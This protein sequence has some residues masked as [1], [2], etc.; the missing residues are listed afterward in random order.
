MKIR[1]AVFAKLG[2]FIFMGLSAQT[3]A[4]FGPGTTWN[5]YN[6]FYL[7]PGADGWTGATSPSALGTAWGYY[8]GNVN[9][10]GGNPDKVGNNL[11]STQ[12]YRLSNANPAGAA[13][14]VY[15]TSGWANTGG[16]GFGYYQDNVAWNG[17]NEFGVANP[18][19][20]VSLGRYD[21]PWFSGAPGLSQ[22]LSNL[23]WM[24]SAW[25]GGNGTAGGEG[26]ASVLT[27]TAPS[28][29][30]FAFA[31]QFVAGNQSSNGASVAIVDNVGGTAL[32][33]R[34][35]LN[36]DAS[37]A[38]S[39]SA[40]YNAGDTVQFQVGNNFSTGNAVGLQVTATAIPEPSSGIMLT[41]GLGAL[42]LIN[43][44]RRR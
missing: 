20:H 43:L 31:G 25:L 35:V 19:P 17:V 8:M 7:S 29:G 10:Y 24:Q 44:R 30:V 9:L 1:N 23:I 38:F 6:D 3:Q 14:P 18:A 16:T 11:N 41:A 5:A 13:G 39:F 40:S 12:L 26:I 36:P 33:A 15:S 27:W 42:G 34:T 4:Q 28:T 2:L 32:L 37:R 21:T 22:G